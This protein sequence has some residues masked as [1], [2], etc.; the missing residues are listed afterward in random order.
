MN[1]RVPV[2]FAIVV[3]VTVAAGMW[4]TRKW[5]TERLLR[6]TLALLALNAALTVARAVL[7]CRGH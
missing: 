3:V 6:W 2:I 5:P 1:Y 4:A 7:S